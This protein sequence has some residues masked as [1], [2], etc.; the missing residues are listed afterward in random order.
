MPMTDDDET[1]EARLG[2]LD[3]ALPLT[4]LPPDRW[5]GGPSGALNRARR[6]DGQ[7]EQAGAA[8]ATGLSIIIPTKNRSQLLRRALAPFVG[9][10]GLEVIVVD[11]DS[12]PEQ[13]AANR[14]ACQAVP[15]CRYIRLDRTHG[16]A[17][18][19]NRGLVASTQAMVWFLDDDDFATGRTL[20][21]VLRAIARDDRRRVLLLPRATVF[22]GTTI[23]VDVP[24]GR[25]D[26][27]ELYRRVGIEVT[28]SCA[29]FPRWALETVG[30]WDERLPALQDTDLMLRVARIARFASL[31]T[32]PVRVDASHPVRITYSL[33]PSTVGKVLFLRKHW[34]TLSLGRRLRYIAQIVGCSSLTRA[35]RLRWQLAKAR[36]SARLAHDTAASPSRSLPFVSR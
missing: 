36:R 22:Q 7:Q 4:E 11:D 24:D 5:T 8:P 17:A 14:H 30:G 23:Q 28:T 16:G 2:S 13:A 35:P 26:K 29:I 25:P 9:R 12:T 32:E 31:P 6:R 21:D 15:G 33:V 10:E 20:N 1:R 34:H 27:F 18:A 19:R 3:R